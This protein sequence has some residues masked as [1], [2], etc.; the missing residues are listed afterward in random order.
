M[1]EDP[2]GEEPAWARGDGEGDDDDEGED[3]DVPTVGASHI[4]VMIDCNPTMFVPSIRLTSDD[5]DDDDDTGG[6]E[7]AENASDENVSQK[8]Q[9]VTPFEAALRAAEKLIR[10][11]VH[12]VAT[13]RGGTRDGVGLM[14]FATRKFNSEEKLQESADGDQTKDT[15]FKKSGEYDEN[16][17]PNA[18]GDDSS[19]DEDDDDDD[20]GGGTYLTSFY[21][22]IPLAPPG[23]EQTLQ[24]RGCIPG[25]GGSGSGSGSRVQQKYRRDLVKEFADIKEDKEGDGTSMEDG[26]IDMSCPLRTAL[27][28]ASKAFVEAK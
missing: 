17:R 12:S 6:G 4:L 1:E 16:G 11:K 23:T 7:E 25:F 26:G 28:E 22:L 24:I 2:W 14:L 21:H 5:D 9:L 18:R 15:A 13:S 19:S 27:H 3:D 10:G 20:F 8:Q